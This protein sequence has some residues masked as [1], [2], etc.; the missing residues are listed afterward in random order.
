[1][2]D[3]NTKV[4]ML[5][6]SVILIW[7]V[8]K[9]KEFLENMP[10]FGEPEGCACY[11]KSG[12]SAERLA[13][14][15]NIVIILAGIGILYQLYFFN[16]S[17]IEKKMM[18]TISYSTLLFI[19]F[20]VYLLFAY[21][22]NDF[23]KSLDKSCKCADKWEKTALYIQAIYYVIII[24]LIIMSVLVLLTVGTI[25]TSSPYGRTII[26]LCFSI[27]AIIAFSVFGGNVNVFLDYAIEH[28]NKTNK[29]GFE[30]GCESKRK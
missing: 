28:S 26:I 13:F 3:Q 15:E 16:S 4:I 1:M 17:D 25:K 27:G 23:R 11:K 29:E 2:S 6:T 30:C 10:P 22:A 19:T 8:V 20:I 21:N 7:I 18:N 24:A 9:I 5:I 12:N 14:L